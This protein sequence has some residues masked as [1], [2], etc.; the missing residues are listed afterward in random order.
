[1]NDGMMT[2]KSLVINTDQ[3]TIIGHGK[4]DLAR[5]RY[6]LRLETDSKSQG[7]FSFSGPVI[8]DG[9][10]SKPNAHA[11]SGALLAR[12]GAVVGLGLLN[13][14]AALLPLIDVGDTTNVDCRKVLGKTQRTIDRIDSKDS[15]AANQPGPPPQP[16]R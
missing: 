6:D 11:E 4:I 8:V 5:K 14:I 10:F 7:L 1:V 3:Q 9:T 13:P 15:T 12:V 16:E 2:V